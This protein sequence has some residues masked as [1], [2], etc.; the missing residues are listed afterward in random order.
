MYVAQP[1]RMLDTVIHIQHHLGINDINQP[2]A[3]RRGDTGMLE[4]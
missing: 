3:D 1:P 4:Q 2:C